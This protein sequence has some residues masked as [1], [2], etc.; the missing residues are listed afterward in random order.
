MKRQTLHYALFACTASLVLL[1][2]CMTFLQKNERFAI[3]YNSN[4]TPEQLKKYDLLVFHQDNHPDLAMLRPQQTVLAY[5]NLGE[6]DEGHLSEEQKTY[7]A[8]KRNEIWNADMVD[9]R[10][11]EWQK[12]VVEY[13]AKRIMNAGFDGFILDTIDNAVY[14]EQIDP[15]QHSGMR[16][17]AINLIKKLRETYPSALIMLNRGFE[18]W[19]DVAPY[20]DMAL[21]ESTLTG[22]NFE[23]QTAFPHKPETLAYYQDKIK[24]AQNSNPHMKI[25]SVDYWDTADVE[26]VKQIYRQQRQNGLIPYVSTPMLDAIHDEPKA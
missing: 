10:H 26:G 3:L 9:I 20:A 5:L 21:A 15:Q 23:T 7:L 13:Y 2:A 18:I 22:Y 12:L 6:A 1:A 19:P 25:Y 14:L 8:L 4:A 17:A 16:L 24:K 11:P